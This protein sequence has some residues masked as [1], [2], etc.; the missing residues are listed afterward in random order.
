[1][2]NEL[3]DLFNW[4]AISCIRMWTG[5]FDGLVQVC[6]I[7]SSL[8]MGILQSCTKPSGQR[9]PKTTRTQDNSFPGLVSRAIR[10]KDNSY[11]EM[12]QGRIQDL[13][14]G[15]AQL[16]WKI[17]KRVGGEGG[18]WNIQLHC[19]SMVPCYKVKYIGI[20]NT[21]IHIHKYKSN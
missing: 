6:S 11:P 7:S 13:K 16:D 15:V 10:T 12:F 18:G 8:A 4:R 19:S 1:M 2:D 21:Y 3:R 9:V 5:N 20:R 14:L 17:L